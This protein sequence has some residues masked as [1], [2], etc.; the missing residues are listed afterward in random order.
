MPPAPRFAPDEEQEI[1]LDA[2][3]A[4]IE[5][6]S[7]LGFTISAI[8]KRAALSV[9][10]L[11]K[12]VQSK[13]DLLV[14]LATR[15]SRHT[16]ALFSEI[17]AAKLSSPQRIIALSLLAPEKTQ[18]FN[19]DGHLNTLVCSEAILSRASSQW[20]SQLRE[21]STQL[22]LLFAEFFHAAAASGELTISNEDEL[23][24][25]SMGCWSMCAGFQ[26]IALMRHVRGSAQQQGL[27]QYPLQADDYPIVCTQRLL[28]TY[29]WRAPLTRSEIDNACAA[30]VAMGYR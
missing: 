14:A 2:A 19:F 22:D 25:L 17:L 11:Y 28:N 20:L 29:Q 3:I 15:L 9:G 4:C 13:E 8:A 27:L 10:S 5:E 24:A 18:L 30:L 26:H 21:A 16:H 6:S 1:V 12:H 7:L 23:Y